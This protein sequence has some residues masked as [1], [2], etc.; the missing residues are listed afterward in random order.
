MA[1]TS[2]NVDDRKPV[3]ERTCPHLL[4]H[5]LSGKFVGDK[6]YISK[7]LASDLRAEGIILLTKFKNKMK[8]RL[9]QWSDKLLMRKRALIESSSGELRRASHGGVP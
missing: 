5:G 9:V 4:L 2:G 3:R 6:G 1:L 8:H 7:A